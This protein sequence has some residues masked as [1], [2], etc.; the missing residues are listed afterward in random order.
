MRT[1]SFPSIARTGNSWD[2]NGKGNFT[3]LTDYHSDCRRLSG[4]LPRPKSQWWLFSEPWAWELSSTRQHA[5]HGTKPRDGSATHRLSDFPAGKLS[6]RV[7]HQ[8]A[9]ISDRPL[10]RDRI[11]G[12]HCRL[13]PNGAPTTIIKDQEH[14]VRCQ[15]SAVSK[16]T[17]SWGS[18]EV[19]GKDNPCKAHAMR[20]APPPP[21]PPLLQ[22]SSVMP[23]CRPATDAGLHSTLPSDRRGKRGTIMVG[24]SPNV[25]EWEIHPSRQSRSIETDASQTG[26]GARCGNLQTGGPRYPKEAAM[27]INCLEL[28]AA[29]LAIQT[30]AKRQE[31]VLIHLKMDSTSALTYIN[32]IGRVSPDLNRLT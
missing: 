24:H 5:G 6:C 12:S 23:S 11:L 2:S 16:S 21:P 15:D 28:L 9:E 1:L 20:A 31:N 30:F 14:S 8:S 22:A 32:K 13:H 25:Q 18:V 29:T 26:R 17:Y 7:H 27:H 3:S 10:T 4:S 19:T